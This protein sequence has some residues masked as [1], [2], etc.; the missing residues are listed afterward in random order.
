MS[1]VFQAKKLVSVL[2][3]SVLVTETIKEAYKV[4][5]P[6]RLPCIYY[7]VQFQKDHKAT[8]WAL[9]D[10]ASKVNAMTL[11]YA[12]QLGLQVQKTEVEVQKI[13]DSLFRTFGMVIAS[14]QVENKLD[15]DDFSKRHSYWLKPV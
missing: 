1:Q 11:A 9:I 10:L 15:R 3:T 5:V 4:I 8:I 6:N 7:L 12:K 13:D 2:A 14:F